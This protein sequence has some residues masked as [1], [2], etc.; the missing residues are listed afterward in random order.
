MYLDTLAKARQSAQTPMS[1]YPQLYLKCVIFHI[2][3]EVVYGVLNSEFRTKQKCTLIVIT[4]GH[5]RCSTAIR[6]CACSRSRRSTGTVG[7]AN[8]RQRI[9]MRELRLHTLGGYLILEAGLQQRLDRLYQK[10]CPA[11][12][13]AMCYGFGFCAGPFS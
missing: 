6:T 7:L 8:V 1:L 11:L 4:I 3:I 5:S 10:Q 12:A 2:G 9:L 13:T